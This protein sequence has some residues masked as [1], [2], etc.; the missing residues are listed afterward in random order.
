MLGH[1]LKVKVMCLKEKKRTK[2]VVLH[3][4]GMFPKQMCPHS[5]LKPMFLV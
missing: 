2:T 4:F 1:M 3:K 5:S